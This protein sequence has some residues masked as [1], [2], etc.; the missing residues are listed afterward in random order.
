MPVRL[1]KI[2]IKSVKKYTYVYSRHLVV[3]QIK[4]TSIIYN[5]LYIIDILLLKEKIEKTTK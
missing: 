4:M 2:Q 3:N 1:L 5:E